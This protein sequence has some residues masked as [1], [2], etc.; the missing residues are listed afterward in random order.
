MTTTNLNLVTVQNLVFDYPTKRAIADT[1]FT[2][3]KGT[4]TALV[5]PNGA[6][7]TTLMKL[8][9]A[10][11]K[12]YSGT[13]VIDGI[14][15]QEEP[16]ECHSK[17]GFLPDFFGL[18][19][20]LTVKQHLEHFAG[21]HKVPKHLWVKRIDEIAEKIKITELLR[22][23]ASDLSRGQRQRLA[24]GAVIFH[25]PKLLLLDEPASGLDPQGRKD[26]SDLILSL[27]AEGITL[28]VSSHILAELAD[29]S[30]RMLTC[31]NGKVVAAE[32]LSTDSTNSLA[33]IAIKLRGSQEIAINELKSIGIENPQLLAD[34]ILIE[35][36]AS[37][38]RYH[39]VLKKLIDS[40]VEVYSFAPVKADIQDVYFKHLGQEVTDES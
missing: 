32:S 11:E 28:V 10:I 9:A 1:S 8:I 38:Q 4:V 15:T 14:D 34:Q 20:Q 40:G 23:P 27:K 39:Q 21:I 36:E 13:V 25:K 30:D 5:G 2:I 37:S 6:G 7:K 12:P 19:D 18:Y 16:R 22:R 24:V 33:K 35:C 3:E 31:S 17:L 26:L 29:Y